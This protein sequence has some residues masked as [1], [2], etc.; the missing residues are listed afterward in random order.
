MWYI[1]RL[2]S[3][4]ILDTV[5]NLFICTCFNELAGA[6]LHIDVY[7]SVLTFDLNRKH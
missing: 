1:L 7:Q 4:L 2:L 3:V 6:F 5:N